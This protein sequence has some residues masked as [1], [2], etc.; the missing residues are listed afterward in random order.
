MPGGQVASQAKSMQIICFKRREVCIRLP[1]A[2]GTYCLR[3]G[4]RLRIATDSK[5]LTEINA[6]CQ[7][8][9]A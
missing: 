9:F 4:S 1:E 2:L 5:A 8:Q 6:L 7:R 3:S